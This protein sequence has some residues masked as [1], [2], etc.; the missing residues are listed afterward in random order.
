[1]SAPSISQ[2]FAA[3]WAIIGPGL[4]RV[5]LPFLAKVAFVVV[6]ASG[7]TAGYFL[8]GETACP[9]VRP[10][11]VAISSP[12][13]LL[14]VGGVTLGG[15]VPGATLMAFCYSLSTLAGFM[16]IMICLGVTLALIRHRQN[17][18]TGA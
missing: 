4:R 9:L 6:A 11:A 13:P 12:E 7:A 1:M 10:V 15:Y 2:R 8:L 17:L 3:A 18:R 5:F 16:A 14:R